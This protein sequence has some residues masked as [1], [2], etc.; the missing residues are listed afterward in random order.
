VPLESLKLVRSTQELLLKRTADQ[1]ATWGELESA[2]IADPTSRA[3]L[4]GMRQEIAVEQAEL[5]ERT[6]KLFEQHEPE[7]DAAQ[8][9]P[10]ADDEGFG[11]LLEGLELPEQK[12]PVPA[13][14][15]GFEPSDDLAITLLGVSRAMRE[16]STKIRRGDTGVETQGLQGRAIELLERLIRQEEESRSEQQS[17]ASGS[18][19]SLAG[20][21]AGGEQAGGANEAGVPGQEGDDADGERQGEQVAD[22]SDGNGERTDGGTGEAGSEEQ[23]VVRVPQGIE[24]EGKGVWGHLPAKTRGMLRSQVPTEYLPS[25]SKQISDYFRALAEMQPDGR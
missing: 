3:K 2:G 1:E 17:G 5:G 25:Y 22:A 13:D 23:G 7:N 16:A 6:E 21:A 15:E 18:E 24:A 4:Q 9:I 8:E 14:S 11:G 19:P 20:G 12:E 10:E